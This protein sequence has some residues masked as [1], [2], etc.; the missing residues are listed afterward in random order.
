MLVA[1]YS[2]RIL[3]EEREAMTEIMIAANFT[4][5]A[6]RVPSIVLFNLKLN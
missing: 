6:E 4:L 2:Y 3:G 1:A 5:G